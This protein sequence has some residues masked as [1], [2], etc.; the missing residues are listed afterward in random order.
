MGMGEGAATGLREPKQ[1]GSVWGEL[2][3]IAM[4]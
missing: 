1:E 3:E 2:L 4:G